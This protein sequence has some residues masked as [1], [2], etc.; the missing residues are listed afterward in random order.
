M[1]NSGYAGDTTM[2]TKGHLV[3]R[4]RPGWRMWVFICRQCNLD[5]ADMTLRNWHAI[6]R[7]R[8]DRRADKVQRLIALLEEVGFP[9]KHY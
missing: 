5:Q 6:L 3:P 2:R 4:S 8:Q 1:T 7:W 9:T